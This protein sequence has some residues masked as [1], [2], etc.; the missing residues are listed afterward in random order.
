MVNNNVMSRQIR[1]SHVRKNNVRGKNVRLKNEEPNAVHNIGK[2]SYEEYLHNNEFDGMIDWHEKNNRIVKPTIKNFRACYENNT[3]VKGILNNL[4]MKCISNYEIVGDNAEAVE[5]IKKCA[6]I[7]KLDDLIYEILLGNFVDSIIF[8]E[9]LWDG[10]Q[11][12]LRSLL[13]DGER[14]NILEIYDTNGYDIIRYEQRVQVNQKYN[15]SMFDF[16]NINYP[17]EEEVI[18]FEPDELFVPCLFRIRGKPHAI[19]KNVLDPAYLLNLF[20][21][22]KMSDV[23]QKQSNALFLKLGDKYTTSEDLVGESVVKSVQRIA[24][25]HSKG[26]ATLPKGVDPVL[27]GDSHLPD[28]PTYCKYLE[29][30][31]FVGLFTPEVAYSSSSSNRSTGVVQMESKSSGYVLTIEFIQEFLSWEISHGVFNVQ[32]ER[33]GFPVDSVWLEFPNEENNEDDSEQQEEDNNSNIDDVGTEI[34]RE[35][36]YNKSTTQGLNQY[37]INNTKRGVETS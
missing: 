7:W 9:R 31:I 8:Y 25:I 20:S 15:R 19:I 18:P 17:Y 14:N 22:H 36:N 26:M 21:L 2:I 12:L 35:M 34:N 23:I 27:I 11:L 32:L 28:I 13:F 30:L 24:D 3:V 10:D 16:D 37:N 4:A 6:E 29:H 5:F 1:R 33:K